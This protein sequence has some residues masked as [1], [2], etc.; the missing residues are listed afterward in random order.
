MEQPLTKADAQKLIRRAAQR[1]D[2]V[3]FRGYAVMRMRQRR[4]DALDVV[5]VLRNAVQAKPAY[6]RNDE[7]RYQISG[8]GLMIIVVIESEEKVWVHNAYKPRARTS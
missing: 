2:G 6:R 8:R 5:R 7:W 4:L 3:G 1:T